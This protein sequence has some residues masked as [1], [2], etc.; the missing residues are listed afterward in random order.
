MAA[1]LF[2]GAIALLP[3][4]AQDI[5]CWL[6]R[7]WNVGAAPAGALII[8]FSSAYIPVTKNAEK[9]VNIIFSFGISIIVSSVIIVLLPLFA[10]SF[11]D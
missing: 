6:R 9:I 1:V 10:Y 7:I 5:Q 2:G 4:Y 11:M 3:I 8:M